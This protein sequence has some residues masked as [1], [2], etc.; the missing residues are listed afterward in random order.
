V[1]SKREDTWDFS[2]QQSVKMRLSILLSLCLVLLMVLCF[3]TV[4]CK[5][6]KKD[7]SRGNKKYSVRRKIQGRRQGGKGGRNLGKRKK[8]KGNAEK[9]KERKEGKQRRLKTQKRKQKIRKSNTKCSGR[10]TDTFCPAEKAQ[11]LNLLYNKVAN[12]FKQLN[13]A[14]AFAKTV[15]NKKGKKD[16]FT[17]DAIILED[18]VGGNFSAPACSSNARQSSTAGEKGQKLKNCTNSIAEACADITIDANVTGDCNTKM[19]AFQTKVTECKSSDACTCW[20]EAFAMKSD[21]SP[22]NAKD[23]MDR[24]K[25]L[26]KSCTTKFGECK[27]AQDGAV[28]LT[29]TCPAS[30]TTSSPVMTTASARR[31]LV[32]DFLANHHVVVKR[33]VHGY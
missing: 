11:A 24:V 32:V 28:E 25:G 3:N 7:V 10:Q 4:D 12:F 22:C 13:R 14:K 6:E 17:N 23:E 18:A 30:A 19:E 5:K 33:D 8:S 31:R 15:K 27:S 9:K 20:K 21:L 1:S 16:D 2:D 29:A 26:K